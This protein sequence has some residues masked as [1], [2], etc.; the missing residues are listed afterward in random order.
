MSSL[1]S[2]FVVVGAQRVKF[3]SGHVVASQ[4][5]RER[6]GRKQVNLKSNCPKESI[7]LRVLEI[8]NP[9]HVIGCHSVVST[10]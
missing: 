9:L 6:A 8:K 1:S 5:V 10:N 4:C 2:S 3:I 7:E